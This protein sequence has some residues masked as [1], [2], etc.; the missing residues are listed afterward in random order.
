MT[1]TATG[2]LTRM[3]FLVVNSL[4]TVMVMGFLMVKIVTKKTRTKMMTGSLTDS[5]QTQRTRTPMVTGFLMVTMTT[6]TV[7]AYPMS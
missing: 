3:N 1:A 4:P 5:T 6:L 2:F 7:T